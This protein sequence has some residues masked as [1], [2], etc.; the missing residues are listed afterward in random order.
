MVAGR[1]DS[2]SSN[3]PPGGLAGA[4]TYALIAH[5]LVPTHAVPP[6]IPEY[7]G[8]VPGITEKDHHH[9]PKALA[10][11]SLFYMQLSMLRL[12]LGEVCSAPGAHCAGT[13]GW[14]PARLREEGVRWASL[15]GY[16]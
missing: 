15:T 4:S 10:S 6:Q 9:S 14:S 8:R 11:G 5:I 16:R 7:Q 12:L 13:G 2:L 3:S 1:P